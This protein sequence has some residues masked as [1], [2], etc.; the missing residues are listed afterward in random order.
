[1]ELV[2]IRRMVIALVW[3]NQDKDHAMQLDQVV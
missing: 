3:A 2:L 1:M